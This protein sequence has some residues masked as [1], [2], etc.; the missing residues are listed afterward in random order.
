MALDPRAYTIAPLEI[1]RGD[2]YAFQAGEVCGHNVVIATLPAGRDGL[3]C[4]A[5]GHLRQGPNLGW[6]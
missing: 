4:D 6:S 2:D 1:E 3:G 5:G